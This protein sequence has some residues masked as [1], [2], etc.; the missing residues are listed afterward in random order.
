[1]EKAILRIESDA[2]LPRLRDLAFQT[3]LTS[4]K[5][6]IN[7][8]ASEVDFVWC[9]IAKSVVEEGGCLR[10]K[11]YRVKVSAPKIVNPF[12]SLP[13]HAQI[14]SRAAHSP[15]STDAETSIFHN[16]RLHG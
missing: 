2:T 7:V 15:R 12:V 6:M 3:E 10:N 5:W 4:G 16:L 11:S 9:R 13:M 1:M 14:V 8:P